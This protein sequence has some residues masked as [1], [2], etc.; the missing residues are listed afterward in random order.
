LWA[1][2]NRTLIEWGG[3][4]IANA[5]EGVYTEYTRQTMTYIGYSL[6]NGQKVWGPT[7]PF[8]STWAYYDWTAPSA[9]GYGNFYAWG[10]AGEVYC[11]DVQTG[12]LKWS[13]NSGNS[14]IDSPF[15]SWPLGT[16]MGHNILADGK[17]YVRAG[18]DYT[19]PVF[20]GAKLYCLNATTGELVWD[21]L[22]FDIIGSP[23]VADGYMVWFNGYDNQVHCYSKGPSATTVAA[24]PKVS[25]HGS[26][27]LVEGT[28]MDKSPG[29]KDSDRT[30]RF[31]NGVPAIADEDMSA[32][33][34]YVY[35][36][37]PLPTNAKGVDVIVE[38]FDP[39]SNYYEVGRATSDATGFYSLAFTPEVPGKYTVVAR[40][41]GSESYYS[42]FAETAINVEQATEATPQPTQA[43]TSLAEQ[44]F[45][46]VSIVLIIAIVAVLVMMIVMFRK[47]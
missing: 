37:Q 7:Q 33:M 5:G 17:L 32:W 29:T 47:R 24:N 2:V 45:L 40:F 41:A 25:V 31:P 14:G 10:L 8:N 15:G 38:V 44:Y 23:A 4:A 39:N 11:W 19:P 3:V 13:W 43:P 34:E 35:Q 20:K 12:A 46:P 42:S 22:N 26:S 27:V 21:T 30:A 1:P 6:E 28:V 36:Q 18:H 16:W 9:I